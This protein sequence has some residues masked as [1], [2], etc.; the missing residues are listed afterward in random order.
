MLYKIFSETRGSCTRE[1]HSSL[2][3]AW[4]ACRFKRAADMT[5]FDAKFNVA[6]AQLTIA[7]ERGFARWPKLKRRLEKPA[8]ADDQIPTSGCPGRM[9]SSKQRA[10]CLVETLALIC[11]WQRLSDVLKMC[12]DY[13]SMR[14][15]KTV[16]EL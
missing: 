15:R 14:L 11:L 13:C 1:S 6:D 5:I 3:Q 10:L 12:A 9:A 8:P 16:I 7:R 2:K 4:S